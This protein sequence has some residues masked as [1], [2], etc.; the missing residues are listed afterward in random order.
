MGTEYDAGVRCCVLRRARARVVEDRRTHRE[1]PVRG[2]RWNAERRAL[3][4]LQAIE[5]AK[6]AAKV[7]LGSGRW[8]RLRDPLLGIRYA[9]G[10]KA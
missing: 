6:N 5:A 10:G 3:W 4:R 2:P 7:C 8:Q 9:N 1:R